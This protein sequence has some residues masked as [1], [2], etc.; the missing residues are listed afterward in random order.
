ME[1]E[2]RRDTADPVFL[3]VA[4]KATWELI[5]DVVLERDR[6]AVQKGSVHDLN[7]FGDVEHACIRDDIV[8]KICAIVAMDMQLMVQIALQMVLHLA[9]LVMMG[10]F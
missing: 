6:K 2:R 5:W 8:L 1:K 7:I 3:G 4:W 9:A 10:M